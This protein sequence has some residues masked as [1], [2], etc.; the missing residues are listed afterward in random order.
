MMTNQMNKLMEYLAKAEGTN[1]H[2]NDKELDITAMY[3]IYRHSNP[4]AK[5]FEEIDYLAFTLGIKEKSYN[6]LDSHIETI[7][8]YI[9]K[10]DELISKFIELA[11]EFYEQ[12]YNRA[13]LSMFHSDCVLAVASMYTTSPKLCWKSIQYGIN[14]MNSNGIIYYKKIAVDGVAG[15]ETIKGLNK[16]LYECNTRKNISLLFES[17]MLLGMTTEYSKLVKLNPKKYME[18]S[19]GWDNRMKKLQ[20]NR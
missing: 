10:R 19:I 1:I 8:K 14:T 16:C 2:Y 3:G 7:N 9:N 6:W 15:E 13:R 20:E 4:S 17:Y 18:Y 11:A 12:F 5:I